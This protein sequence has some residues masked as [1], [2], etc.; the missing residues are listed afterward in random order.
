MNLSYP[1]HMSRPGTICLPQDSP[2]EPL[3]VLVVEDEESVRLV[4]QAVLEDA[5]YEVSTA[6]TVGEATRL[7]QQSSLDYFSLVISDIY[8]TGQRTQPDGYYFYETYSAMFPDLSFLLMSAASN[9]A[10]LPGVRSGAVPLLMK[11]FTIEALLGRV[12]ALLTT[13]VR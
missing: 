5:G 6:A 9:A 10:D 11:P 1:A 12:Q 2:P 3:A 4:V 13:Q 7:I 8:L